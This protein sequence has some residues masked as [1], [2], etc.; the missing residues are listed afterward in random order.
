MK[1]NQ[2]SAIVVDDDL[3]PS[4]NIAGLLERYPFVNVLRAFK[5]TSPAL[6]YAI[7]NQPDIIF[8]DVEDPEDAA[9]QLLLELTPNI[10]EI[11]IADFHEEKG[12][13][14][15]NGN[16]ILRIQKQDIEKNLLFLLKSTVQI[17]NGK[18]WGKKQ[19]ASGGER[20]KSIFIK[21]RATFR[22]LPLE[23]IDYIQASGGGIKVFFNGTS[24]KAQ[25]S[26][27]ILEDQLPGALFCRVHKSYVVRLD[28]IESF[29]SS[30]I[31]LADVVI[32]LRRAHRQKFESCIS[33][34]P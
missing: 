19:V 20:R 21:S 10:P 29:N 15:I 11:I 4:A 27:R 33:K 30:Q 6:T 1:P 8:L 23:E 13:L 34:V 14:L 12:S 22:R 25:T 2:F 16:L 3:V 5:G 32:P 17:I 31:Q 18:I 28:R 9:V 26:L 24:L 7:R